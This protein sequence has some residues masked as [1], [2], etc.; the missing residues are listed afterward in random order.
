M[1]I[2]D[3]TALTRLNGK[4]A[5]YQKVINRLT[6]P[7]VLEKKGTDLRIQVWRLFYEQKFGGKGKKKPGI[8]MLELRR[9]A[10]AGIGTLVRNRDLS[11]KWGAAPDT[12]NGKKR[13]GYK[14]SLWQK[15]V[16]QEMERRKSGIGVLA[17]G[18]LS[19]QFQK[20][21]NL[22]K[23]KMET[24]SKVFGPMVRLTK[25]ETS[26][27]IEGFTP[28][29]AELSNRYNIANRAIAAVEKDVDVYLN[30]KME[31]ARKKVFG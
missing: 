13:Q 25:D 18:F 9:R 6:I 27:T 22:P 19:K 23:G 16:W 30:R 7:E 14:L 28:Y 26:Y 24:T 10:K 5:D 1:L 15:L 20:G 4:L 2:I 12:A 17:I 29:L 21:F 8:P 3:T 11:G 31:E